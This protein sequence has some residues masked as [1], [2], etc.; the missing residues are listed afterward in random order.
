L[1]VSSQIELF[2]YLFDILSDNFVAV[3]DQNSS[4]AANRQ[5]SRLDSI[6]FRHSALTGNTRLVATS[7]QLRLTQAVP[8]S[9]LRQQAL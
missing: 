5:P 3:F 4:A 2:D 8:T 9:Q 7:H 6:D 1:G